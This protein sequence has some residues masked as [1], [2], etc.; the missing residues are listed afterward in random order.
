MKFN[1]GDAS[2]RKEAWVL[3]NRHRSQWHLWFAWY[4]VRVGPNDCRWFETVR[5]VGNF[6]GE[7][8]WPWQWESGFVYWTYEEVDSNEQ[9]STSG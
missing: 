8:W 5:R 2:D 1:C 3:K 6:Y 4:P 9:V 7:F